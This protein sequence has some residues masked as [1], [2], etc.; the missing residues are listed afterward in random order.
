MPRMRKTFYPRQSANPWGSATVSVAPVG[1][2]P[3]E[4]RSASIRAIRGQAPQFGVPS[5]LAEF[6]SFGCPDSR[7]GFCMP[8]W[9]GSQSS[10]FPSFPSVGVSPILPSAFCLLPSFTPPFPYLCSRPPRFSDRA[11]LRKRLLTNR[12]SRPNLHQSKR[13]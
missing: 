1:V 12:F 10:S 3:T 4:S 11:R 6:M 2:S 7:S 5:R 13:I 9:E 8:H